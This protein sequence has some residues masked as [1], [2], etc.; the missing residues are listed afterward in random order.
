MKEKYFIPLKTRNV[1]QKAGL[2][3]AGR[4]PLSK[5]PGRRIYGV[6][7]VGNGYLRRADPPE[8]RPEDDEPR[9]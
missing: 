3:Q 8:L 6:K 4:E 2:K 7:E 5:A 9:E 1:K